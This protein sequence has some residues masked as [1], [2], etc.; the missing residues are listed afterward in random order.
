MAERIYL[1]RQTIEKL[2]S[3]GNERR[4][5]DNA[6]G[7]LNHMSI[8][9]AIEELAGLVFQGKQDLVRYSEYRGMRGGIEFA[10]LLIK[11][12]EK[13]EETIKPSPRQKAV[14]ER[15]PPPTRKEGV[16]AR[17]IPGLNGFVKRNYQVITTGVLAIGSLMGLKN[18]IPSS[19]VPDYTSPQ[20]TI[21]NKG[22]ETA[23]SGKEEFV[24]PP[25]PVLI[26]PRVKPEE[27]QKLTAPPVTHHIRTQLTDDRDTVASRPLYDEIM[28]HFKKANELVRKG[29]IDEAS[30]E[31][32]K[33]VIKLLRESEGERLHRYDDATGKSLPPGQKAKGNV[34]IGI[35][36]NMDRNGAEGD[37]NRAFAGQDPAPDFD[38]CYKGEENITS[39]QAYALKL[40]DLQ[41][42]LPRLRD[43]IGKETFNTML[44]Q[45]RGALLSVFFNG[46]SL[47]GPRMSDCISSGGTGAVV[48]E[49]ISGCN[50]GV[51]GL[52]N[53]RLLEAALYASDPDITASAQA[54]GEVIRFVAAESP[55]DLVIGLKG[56]TPLSFGKDGE[57]LAVALAPI[58][59]ERRVYIVDKD[60]EC[61][62]CF[63]KGQM[64]T[65]QEIAAAAAPQR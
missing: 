24:F 15:T 58:G 26:K 23:S 29:N 22:I 39:D 60:E 61:K 34:T 56:K 47:I 65:P 63:S 54:V 18:N 36:F 13:V 17:I 35:G 27:P 14:E 50:D 7:V 19:Q 20:Q 9:M 62:L 46:E 32:S 12:N 8:D 53:R 57:N 48:E 30:T 31:F 51:P 59:T 33:G 28:A 52:H 40:Q 4:L 44:T 10:D 5:T 2:I 49:I 25:E 11:E 21:E 6:L 37:W 3:E 55:G 38:R 45:Q 64:K 1:H 41:D 16:L 43:R 42:R